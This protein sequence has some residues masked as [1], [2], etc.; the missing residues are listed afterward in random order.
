MIITSFV[1]NVQ[2]V[3]QIH[4]TL[5]VSTWATLNGKISPIS[6]IFKRKFI[7]VLNPT[8]YHPDN[9]W[10]N[11]NLQPIRYSSARGLFGGTELLQMHI[12]CS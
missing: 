12:S 8:K 6:P 10:K 5:E 3:I 1:R 9:D 4:E 11:K 2:K 7:Q